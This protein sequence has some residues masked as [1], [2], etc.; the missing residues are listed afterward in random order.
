MGKRKREH[1]EEI[2]VDSILNSELPSVLSDI[3]LEYLEAHP[4]DDELVTK[5]EARR[6][7]G[8]NEKEMDELEVAAWRQNPHRRNGPLMR[9]YSKKVLKEGAI[10]KFGSLQDLAAYKNKKKKKRFTIRLEK[11]EDGTNKTR[12]KKESIDGSSTSKRL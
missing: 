11:E 3:V 1:K 4:E 8:L 6:Q 7:F 2:Y 10:E 9:L 5:T 12:G